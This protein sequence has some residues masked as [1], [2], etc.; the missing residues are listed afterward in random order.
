ML[1]NKD[2]DLA[3]GSISCSLLYYF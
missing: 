3:K 1:L 2:E